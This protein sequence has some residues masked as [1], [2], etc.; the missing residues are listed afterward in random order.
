L[1]IQRSPREKYFE[2]LYSQSNG[3]FRSA[4]RL[5][6]ASIVWADSGSIRLRPPDAPETGSLAAALNLDD[7][8]ALQAIFQHGSL[9][10]EEIA[11]IF[12]APLESAVDR[13]ER[14]QDIGLLEYQ[15]G[16]PGLRIRPRI[17]HLVRR[18]LDANNLY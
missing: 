18:V 14:L 12:D 4:F 7:M 2:A 13:L 17:A 5:W 11:H 9:T 3:V 15:E 16:V 8:F 10:F 6:N 1:G